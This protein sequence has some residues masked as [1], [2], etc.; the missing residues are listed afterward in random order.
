MMMMMMANSS[1]ERQEDPLSLYA[2]AHTMR[3]T[4]LEPLVSVRTGVKWS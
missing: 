4:E 3:D 2:F 1:V